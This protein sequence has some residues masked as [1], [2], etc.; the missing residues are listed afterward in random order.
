M[1]KTMQP[2]FLFVPHKAGTTRDDR[3]FINTHLSHR[4]AE[5]RRQGKQRP[6]ANTKPTQKPPQPT[7]KLPHRPTYDE[8]VKD[9]SSSDSDAT[10]VSTYPFPGAEDGF[11]KDDSQTGPL[12]VSP[13]SAKRLRNGSSDP[14]SSTLI[15]MTAPVRALLHFN[16]D[17]FQPWGEGIEKGFHKRAAFSNKFF[18]T[19]NE[20][21]QDKTTAYAFLAR[22]ASMAAMLSPNENLAMA[23]TGFKSQAYENLRQDMMTYGM[24]SD[25]L[26]YAQMFSL[27]AMEIA[28]HNLDAAAI[29]ARTLQQLI[30]NAPMTDCVNVG[31][32]LI[33]S[34]LWHE[35]LR[36][37]FS[38]Q[39]PAFEVDRLLD[40]AYWRNTL[41][42]AKSELMERGLMPPHKTNGFKAAGLAQDIC[43]CVGELRFMSDLTHAF[44]RAPDLVTEDVM[45]ALGHRDPLISSRL[46]KLYNDS[47]D[48]LVGG[49][50]PGFDSEIQTAAASCLAARF[51]YRVATSHE[52]VDVLPTTGFQLYR[53]YGTHKPILERLKK[54][55]TSY[56]ESS[57]HLRKQNLW[58][59]ILYVGTLAE[60]ANT[61]LDS[62]FKSLKGKYFHFHFVRLARSMGLFSWAD[63]EEVLST[64]LYSDAVGVRSRQHFEDGMSSQDRG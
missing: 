12:I 62:G 18:Q 32:D 10:T 52:S 56:R 60:R 17:M 23:A 42:A 41:A 44:E 61:T 58:L 25:T 57:A 20:L 37:G 27:L 50:Y 2:A 26:L 28:A 38:L 21:L 45:R 35:C 36:G 51:W 46:L 1:I 40:Q 24:H 55:H 9:S 47:Q 7:V 59:W 39:R 11:E 43:A 31:E 14:F 8:E 33:C 5:R 64:F 3:R 49:E 6:Q 29:H 13:A 22:L 34:V 16:D 30:Q 48:Y 4:A 53:I 63:V 54:A 15:P 19:G